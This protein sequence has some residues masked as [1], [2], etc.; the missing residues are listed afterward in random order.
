MQMIE[1][2]LVVVV[3][4]VIFI[5]IQGSKFTNFKSNLM[6]EFGRHGIS[7]QEADRIYTRNR[8][9]IHVMQNEG[10]PIP[11]IVRTIM[12]DENSGL[13]DQDIETI[14]AIKDKKY[15]THNGN[16]NAINMI[17]AYPFD[18][19]C[20]ISGNGPQPGGAVN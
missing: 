1:I 16:S 18:A 14:S 3:I 20:S 15:K 4:F 2:I 10:M 17:K 6:N 9:R 12:E 19:G 5:V 13:S 7:F 8:D 11:E